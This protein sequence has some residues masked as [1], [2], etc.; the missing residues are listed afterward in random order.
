MS[1]IK[2][3]LVCVT[4]CDHNLDII[5]VELSKLRDAEE[6][7]VAVSA[8]LLPS[9]LAYNAW[10][11][12]DYGGLTNKILSFQIVPINRNGTTAF[13]GVALIMHMSTYRK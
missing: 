10:T 4:I 13:S 5:G 6:A 1:D 2:I 7:D 12:V 11:T 8:D 9:L 3:I